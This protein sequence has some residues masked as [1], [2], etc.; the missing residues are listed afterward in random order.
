MF[1]GEIPRHITVHRD[2]NACLRCQKALLSTLLCI[3]STFQIQFQE[4]SG[5][6]QSFVVSSKERED[7]CGWRSPFQNQM[8]FSVLFQENIPQLMLHIWSLNGTGG[9]QGVGGFQW[10]WRKSFIVAIVTEIF[11][12]VFY[13]T[14][15]LVDFKLSERT[16]K[17]PLLRV[18]NLP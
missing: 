9:G 12:A 2:W 17:L 16:I 4:S 13:H 6:T 8:C 5:G 11:F 1:K 3:Q 18:N 7:F 14:L 10:G 15:Q